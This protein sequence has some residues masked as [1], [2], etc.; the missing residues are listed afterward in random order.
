MK[1]IRLVYGQQNVPTACFLYRMDKYLNQWFLTGGCAPKGA[2][3]NVQWG[4]SP[5]MLY[6]RDLQ[7]MARE[8][9]AACEATSSG[10]QNHFVNDEK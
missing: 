10:P 8:P 4:V 7:T 3:R 5:Y 9:N 6:N 1:E 2:S